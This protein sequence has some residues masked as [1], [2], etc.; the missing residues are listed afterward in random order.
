MAALGFARGL[1]I[2]P[3]AGRRHAGFAFAGPALPSGATLTRASAATCVDAGGRIVTHAADTPRF[4]HDPVTLAPRGLLIEAAATNQL[5]RSSA[6]QLSPWSVS[7]A[8]LGAAAPS[9]DGGTG[10]T[11]VSD[12]ATA[13]YGQ[14]S[15]SVTISA[16]AVGSIFIAKDGVPA[17]TRAVQFRFG[18][19]WMLI[20]TQSGQIVAAA[21]GM[22][23]GIADHGG[24][25][26]VWITLTG[27]GGSGLF[28]VLPAGATGTTLSAAATGSATLWGAQMEAGG[29]PSSPMATGAAA[30]T[31]AA[32][33]LRLQWGMHGIADGGITVRYRFDDGSTQLVGAT[34]TGG[35]AEVPATLARRHLMS[36]ELA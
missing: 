20:D 25:W 1:G 32:D 7:N 36:A 9:P 35:V 30:V 8:T 15:Q 34:V 5:A 13:A 6:F 16:Q 12:A 2:A 21:S 3:A 28:G 22:E 24:F 27:A 23:G 18:A 14:L 17:A 10:A 4:D 33:V 29:V 19:P 26:R 31:R 11:Q